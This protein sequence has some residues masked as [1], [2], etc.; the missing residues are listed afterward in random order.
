[1]TGKAAM[2][3]AYFDKL[4]AASMARESLLCIGLQLPTGD[5]ASCLVAGAGAIMYADDPRGAAASWRDRMRRAA[6]SATRE[7]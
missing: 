6:Q 2:T 4:S 7:H 3:A 5:A 1:M